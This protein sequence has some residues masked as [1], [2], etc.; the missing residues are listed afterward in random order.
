MSHFIYWSKKCPLYLLVKKVS[1]DNMSVQNMSVEKTSQ[2]L[3]KRIFW[4]SGTHTHPF[5]VTRLDSMG[6]LFIA[7]SGHTVPK[8]SSLKKRNKFWR[9]HTHSVWPDWTALGFVLFQPYFQKGFMRCQLSYQIEWIHLNRKAHLT[10][11]MWSSN[12]QTDLNWIS[13]EI[14]R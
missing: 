11:T 7:A 14:F 1:L 6:L 12:L 4:L 2:C 13:M 5:S 8:S 3:K 9:T 10:K